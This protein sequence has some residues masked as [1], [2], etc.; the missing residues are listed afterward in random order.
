MISEAGGILVTAASLT[1]PRPAYR[2]LED[3][4]IFFCSPLC[5]S[6]PVLYINPDT[7]AIYGKN[8]R[9]MAIG[10]VNRKQMAG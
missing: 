8:P 6:I 4:R 5:Q 1:M 3:I 9:I 2:A 10:P 7:E